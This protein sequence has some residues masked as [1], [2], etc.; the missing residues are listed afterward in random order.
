MTD[1]AQDIIQ[2]AADLLYPESGQRAIDVKF[3]LRGDVS[4]VTLARQVIAC[5]ESLGRPDTVVENL[6]APLTA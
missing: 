5:F 4:A 1:M 6:D 3:F 2:R